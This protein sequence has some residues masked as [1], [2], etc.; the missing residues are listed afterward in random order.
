MLH[1]IKSRQG[2]V[3][4]LYTR[5]RIEGLDDASGSPGA[6]SIRLGWI[7]QSKTT[8]LGERE[9]SPS[10][11]SDVRRGYQQSPVTFDAAGVLLDL[12]RR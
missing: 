2:N 7:S 6:S 1:V 12:R 9:S 8:I 10:A 5:V 11:L 3:R 4:V